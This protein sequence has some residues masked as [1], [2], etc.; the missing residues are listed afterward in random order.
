MEQ[1][2]RDLGAMLRG[3][4]PWPDGSQSAPPQTER[5]ALKPLHVD[6]PTAELMARVGGHSLGEITAPSS[7]A[8]RAQ[9]AAPADPAREPAP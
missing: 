3:E 2:A 5:P 7:A 9:A 6:T 8:P 1:R 4:R